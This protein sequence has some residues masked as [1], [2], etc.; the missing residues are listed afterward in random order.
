M[1]FPRQGCWN[2]LPFPSPGD[3]PDPGT[4]PTSLALQAGSLPADHLESSSFF[5]CWQTSGCF[6][7]WPSVRR[8]W[9]FSSDGLC[10]LPSTLLWGSLRWGRAAPLAHF[11]NGNPNPQWYSVNFKGSSSLLLESVEEAWRQ[12]SC[13]MQRLRKNGWMVTWKWC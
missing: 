8:T 4:E 13:F 5:F 10:F 2:G 11:F 12:I 7:H 1:G 9:P 3:L 6:E